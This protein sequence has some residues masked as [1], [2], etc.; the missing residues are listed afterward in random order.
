M[1]LTRKLALFCTSLI[2]LILISDFVV[3]QV[4]SPQITKLDINPTRAKEYGWENGIFIQAKGFGDPQSL[5][6]LGSFNIIIN[7]VLIAT[8]NSYSTLNSGYTFNPETKKSEKTGVGTDEIEILHEVTQEMSALFK[9]GKNELILL[10][11]NSKI[12][13]RIEFT[14]SQIP[15]SMVPE[16]T[17]INSM[18]E[19]ITNATL[20]LL[21]PNYVYNDN[22]VQKLGTGIELNAD[23]WE[24]S[25]YFVNLK[26]YYDISANGFLYAPSSPVY[27]G[28]PERQFTTPIIFPTLDYTGTNTISIKNVDTKTGFTINFKFVPSVEKIFGLESTN[29]INEIVTPPSLAQT[30]FSAVGEYVMFSGQGFSK[31]KQYILYFNDKQVMPIRANNYGV[32]RG[33]FELT[34]DFNPVVYHLKYTGIGFKTIDPI[35]KLNILAVKDGNN[36]AIATIVLVSAE[37]RG[38]FTRGIPPS[39][40]LPPLL[41]LV[42]DR[43]HYGDKIDIF[44]QGLEPETPYPLTIG[45]EF[46]GEKMNV[47]SDKY[48]KLRV[49]DIMINPPILAKLYIFLQSLF[50]IKPSAGIVQQATEELKNLQGIPIVIQ[51]TPTEGYGYFFGLCKKQECY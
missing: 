48:G 27:F 17:S 32:V 33:T 5:S 20:K 15:V 6:G 30:D 23:W 2:L 19:N 22:G 13:V 43:G 45:F 4:L 16:V 9:E 34:N 28:Y 47:K 8:S 1:N 42:P 35:S 18:G 29:L 31:N 49:N 40:K 14:M 10:N 44:V 25:I 36:T 46:S 12:G 41:W 26:G 37:T 11:E 7:G 38:D 39:E 50:G 21:G 3:A 24:P 51:T